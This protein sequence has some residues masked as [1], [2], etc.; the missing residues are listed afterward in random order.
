M[1][2]LV[3]Q[4]LGKISRKQLTN[5]YNWF[6]GFYFFAHFNVSMPNLKL[7]VCVCMIKNLYV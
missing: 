6:S 7:C 2:A 4:A 3:Y 1:C 5:Y